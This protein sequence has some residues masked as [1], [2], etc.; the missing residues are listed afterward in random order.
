MA[1]RVGPAGLNLFAATEEHTID[2]Y[3]VRLSPRTAWCHVQE[4]D[5]ESHQGHARFRR[6]I[7]GYDSQRM[8]ERRQ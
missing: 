7:D 1:G 6:R 3:F 2:V 8:L 4:D 5:V